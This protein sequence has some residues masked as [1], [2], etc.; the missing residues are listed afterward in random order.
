MG[1]DQNQI[2]NTYWFSPFYF[3]V[4]S[5]ADK[6]NTFKVFPLK[7]VMNIFPIL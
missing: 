5:W 7:I 3:T 2:M 4:N 1:L 6:K